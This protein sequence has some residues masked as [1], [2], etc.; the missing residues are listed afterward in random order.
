MCAYTLCVTLS[1]CW[2]T[3]GEAD[4]SSVLKHMSIS[5]KTPSVIP[6]SVCVL[7]SLLHR[8]LRVACMIFHHLWST[9]RTSTLSHYMLRVGKW[10]FCNNVCRCRHSFLCGFWRMVFLEY[11]I[12]LPI[13]SQS[14]FDQLDLE[15]TTEN[16]RWCILSVKPCCVAVIVWQ[17]TYAWAWI[18]YYNPAC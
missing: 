15:C 2:H 11:L 12:I 13:H 3:E 18:C 10:H 16:I 7:L 9:P 8:G 14:L 17:H 4:A 1:N 5:D 6:A